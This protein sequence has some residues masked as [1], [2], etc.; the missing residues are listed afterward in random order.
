MSVLFTVIVLIGI[1]LMARM[2]FIMAKYNGMNPWL[3]SILTILFGAIP[4]AYVFWKQPI[5]E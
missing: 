5:K 4:M 1:L 2:T 3:W